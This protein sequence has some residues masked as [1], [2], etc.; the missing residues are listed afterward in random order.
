M[1]IREEPELLIIGDRHGQQAFQ[2]VDQR[3]YF[4]SKLDDIAIN[5]QL[6]NDPSE[7]KRQAAQRFFHDQLLH[8]VVQVCFCLRRCVRACMPSLLCPGQRLTRCAVGLS[9]CACA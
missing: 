3:H 8:M 2:R 1:L 4:Q 6:Y 5:I 9:V 7:P